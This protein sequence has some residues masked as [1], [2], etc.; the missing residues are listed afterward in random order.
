M[1]L[2]ELGPVTDVKGFFN[3]VVSLLENDVR[4][5]KYPWVTENLYRRSLG[6]DEAY[7]VKEELNSIKAELS[8][9]PSNSINWV[10]FGIDKTRTRLSLGEKNLSDVF[11]NFFEAF[12]EALECTEIYYK[13]CNEYIPI[14]IGCTDI[15]YYMDDV[16]RSSEEYA[17]LGQN[18]LPFWMA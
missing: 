13:T 14:R 16:N 7:K 10:S 18:D 4:C 11:K 15:P 6:Y 9:I 8:S 2:A 17:A 5:S 1:T 12:D 3:I